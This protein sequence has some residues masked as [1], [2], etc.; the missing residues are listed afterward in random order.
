LLWVF[1]FLSGINVSYGITKEE[2]IQTLINQVEERKLS[3]SLQWKALLHYK[4]KE[5]L[6]D[7]PKFFISKYGKNNPELELKETIKAFFESEKYICKFPLR[8]WW[9]NKE[10][11]FDK[12]FLP[13]YNCKELKKFL[14]DIN[15]TKAYL[16]FA[17]AHINSP[18]SMFGHTL[19]RI[20]TPLKSKLVSHA[21]N[22]SAIT[23][24][25][26]GIL[27]AFKGIF[28]FYKGYFSI[29]PYYEKLKQYSDKD[30]RDLWE[31]KLNLTENEVYRMTLH[32]WELQDIYS[33]YYFFN[34]NCS[35]NLLF[36]ID[37]VKPEYRITDKFKYWVIPVDTIKVL[38]NKKLINNPDYRPSKVTKINF[39]SSFLNK[40][41]KITALKIATG[42]INP[43]TVLDLNIPEK[44]KI[45]ILDVSTNYLQYLV[46]KRKINKST[47]T[48]KLIK[49]LSVRSKFKDKIIYKYPVPVSPEK[50]HNSKRVQISA[51]LLNKEKFIEIGTRPAYHD[52][53]D[54]DEGF[55]YG[56]KIQFLD[57]KFRYYTD[58]KKFQI[59]KIGIVEITSITPRNVFFKPI[60]WRVNFGI[61][62]RFVNGEKQKL[63]LDINPGGGFAFNFWKYGL[64]Y[65]FFETDF[66]LSDKLKRKYSVGAG[67][68][69]GILKSVNNFYKFHLNLKTFDYFLGN[70]NNFYKL[71]FNQRFKINLQNA[72]KLEYS[73]FK[74]YSKYKTEAKLSFLHYF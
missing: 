31:Y 60:S 54:L 56:S 15:P 52:L 67:I 29:L 41:Q 44:K 58:L 22:Y 39:I 38:K 28:G 47:Y 72:V 59:Q 74:T 63:I 27:F 16:V 24:D 10:L 5:S 9:L 18:A 68:S 21:V 71:S 30:S 3:Q 64:V 2:Y 37:V 46:S 66:S 43:N 14:K 65:G 8:F 70:K 50:S 40:K 48:K 55:K 32:V 7:D 25:T 19:I 36:L 45:Y 1:L 73:R 34:E 42:K 26:N 69:T 33:Y 51:G 4:N 13:D 12:Q 17:D 23:T 57:L 11:N 53:L 35:Y 61:Y 49:I 62:R 20:D 6:I